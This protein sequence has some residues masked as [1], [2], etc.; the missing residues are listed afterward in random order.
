M[1]TILASPRPT[2]SQHSIRYLPREHGATAM[3]ITPIVCAAILARHWNWTELATL[4]AGFAALAAKDPLV[5]LVR[6]RFLWKQQHAETAAALRWFAGWA[7]LLAAGGIALLVTWP[8]APLVG[9]GLGVG[10]FTA[11]AIWVNFKNRQRSTLFQI[12]SAAAL[13][14]TSLAAC[15]SALGFIAPWCWWLWVL[16]A[17][18]AATGILV[19]HARLDGRIAARKGQ[20]APLQ[21]R[22]AAQAAIVVLV[23]TAVAAAI[24]KHGLIALALLVAAAGYLYD[25]TAQRSAESLQMPLMVV[26]RRA[27]ALSSVYAALL[28]A[29][30]W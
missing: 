24:L 2:A 18:Q 19:V 10:C 16:L 20:P 8:I 27:L 4:A 29:G 9:M 13:T 12:V 6:Q 21:F 11:L 22:R 14:S 15:Q 25:L 23:C 28:I 7:A 3:L 17:M 1:A 26:G 30:L 5:V